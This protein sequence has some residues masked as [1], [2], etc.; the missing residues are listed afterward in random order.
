M[1]KSFFVDDL[2][3]RAPTSIFVEGTFEQVHKWHS[4]V[5]ELEAASLEP[6]PEE[7]MYTYAKEQLN[8][9]RREGASLLGF[10]WDK[11]NDT[12]R[13]LSAGEG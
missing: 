2:I 8:I 10:S 13:E 6:V 12:C 5:K 3:S 1:Q 4:N 7:D 11:E 9:P